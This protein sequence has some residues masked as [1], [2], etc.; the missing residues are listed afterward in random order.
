M[1]ELY[2]N[3]ARTVLA[4][5]LSQIATSL[6]VAAGTGSLFPS[7]TGGDYSTISVISEDRLTKEV[8]TCT[9]RSGDTLTVTRG[10]DPDWPAAPFSAGATVLGGVYADA[11]A[12]YESATRFVGARVYN[13]G[14]VTIPNNTQ[15]AIP[16]DSER[17]DTHAFHSTVTNPSRLTIPA[18]MAGYYHMG[19]SFQW[20]VSGA[21]S[22]RLAI[23]QLNGTTPIAVNGYQAA[24]AANTYSNIS[25]DY[26]LAVGDYV[27]LHA[28]QLSAADLDI[29]ANIAWSPELWIHRVGG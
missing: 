15:T 29:Q 12:R 5:D 1:A 18:G 16:L 10:V 23:I 9:A 26:H 11:L 3:F 20:A 19:G 6:S 14:N 8:M 28:Y 25:C 21:P 2:S 13:T 22:L 7:P 4:A 24:N 17:Y 27:E